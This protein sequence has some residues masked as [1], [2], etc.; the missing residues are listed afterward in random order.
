MRLTKKT[1]YGYE[2][3]SREITQCSDKLGQLEDI[4]EE[5]EIDDLEDLRERLTMYKFLAN[6]E[7]S[8]VDVNAYN[9][10]LKDLDEYHK[11][12][13][14]LGI[15]LIT[16]FKA[17]KQETLFIKTAIDIR[18]T[19]KHGEGWAMKSLMYEDGKLIIFTDILYPNNITKKD[20]LTPIRLQLE[21][22]G[23]TWALDKN[24]L[25]NE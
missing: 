2:N 6:H 10:M 21:D 8:C 9:L 25:T 22:Y 12:E 23:K 7:M 19:I 14:E 5:F 4:E 3:E 20:W 11:I 18:E 13:D 17:L 15:D 1:Q 24:D 16:L